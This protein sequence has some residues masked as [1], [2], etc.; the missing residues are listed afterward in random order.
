MQSDLDEESDEDE[1]ELWDR[2]NNDNNLDSDTQYPIEQV[3]APTTSDEPDNQ[4]VD[5]EELMIKISGFQENFV[6]K[7]PYTNVKLSRTQQRQ[8]DYKQLY[9]YES[10]DIENGSDLVCYDWKIQNET[11]LSQ[12]TS[13]RLRFSS[14]QTTSKGK[15]NNTW[16]IIWVYLD[17]LTGIEITLLVI[18]QHAIRI[19]HLTM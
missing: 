15:I 12:Y 9:E 11:I 3:G 1:E 17:S 10:T 8:L 14:K 4:R 16:K 19:H 5:F 13:I 2:K 18:H 7:L 6:N